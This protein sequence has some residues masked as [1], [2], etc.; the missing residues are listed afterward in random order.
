M[1]HP[2]VYYLWLA[3][4]ASPIILFVIG[5]RAAL[6][7]K[8][9]SAIGS[10]CLTTASGMWLLVALLYPPILGDAYGSLRHASLYINLG[11]CL[12]GLFGGVY[13]KPRISPA[14]S[15]LALILIWLFIGAISSAA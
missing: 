5:W 12:I 3:L 2:A 10:L 9:P 11:L 4:F 14:L 1:H 7:H 15:A 6:R 8:S 13:R